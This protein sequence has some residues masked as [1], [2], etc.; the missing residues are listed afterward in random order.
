[1]SWFRNLT[2]TYDRVSGI[3]GVVDEKGNVLLPRNHMLA[4]TN[5]C[6]ALDEKGLFR[7]AEVSPLKIMIPCTVKSETSRTVSIAPHPLH[8]QLGYLATSETKYNAYIE[9][10]KSWKDSHPKVSAVYAYIITGSIVDDLQRYEIDTTSDKFDKQFIRFRVEIPGD[11]TPNIWEDTAVSEAWIK[12]CKE[13]QQHEETLCY[14]TGHIAPAAEKHPKGINMSTYGA[15]LVSCNDNTNYTYKGRFNKA[16][17]ANSISS[18]ASHKAHAMLKYLI[19][20]QGYKCDTQAVVAWAID[21]GAAQPDPFANTE[22]I[23]GLYESVSD[24]KQIEAQTEIAA[25]YSN[26]LRNA[27]SSKGGADSLKNMSR[28]VAIIAVDAATTGRMGV[29]FY[30]ELQ[31]DEYVESIIHWHETCCWRFRREKREYISAPSVNRII[32]AVYGEP[33][34]EGYKKIQKQARERLLSHIFCGEPLDRG[35][36]IA[37]VSRASNPFSFSKQDGGWDKRKW[38]NA[39]GVTCAVIRK[40]YTGKG[41]GISMELDIKRTDRDYLFGRLLAIADRLESHARYL[42]TGKDDTDKRPTNAVRYL[43][44][45]AAKPLRTWRL[46]F[47]QLNPYIQRLNGAEWYQRQIDD[48][49]CLFET[50]DEFSDKPLGGKYLLGYS[51]QRR[52]LQP[53]NTE[54]DETNE[55]D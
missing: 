39:I 8:E 53:K 18:E 20:T 6:I 48:I 46:I 32:A 28:R 49:L 52:A 51:L 1:M 9:L 36:L 21:D 26:K 41:E 16:E 43:S 37:A 40:Y 54:G 45:F 27:L 42:Q 4:G 34:G 14:V 55:P 3:V 24:D 12:H 33:K 13:T 22:D 2:E 44:A 50:D 35:W 17:Q 19:A 23:L 7:R 38:I 47:D 15:K 11:Q 25:D 5:I 31:S 10:L 29:T 30:Q